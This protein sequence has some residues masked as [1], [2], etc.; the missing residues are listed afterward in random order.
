[1]SC[2]FGKQRN[3]ITFRFG[4]KTLHILPDVFFLPFPRPLSP[5]HAHEEKYGWLARLNPLSAANTYWHKQ[6]SVRSSAANTNRRSPQSARCI[7]SGPGSSGRSWKYLMTLAPWVTCLSTT[8]SRFN[9]IR[10]D[11]SKCGAMA[12]WLMKFHACANYTTREIT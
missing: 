11:R 3:K 7:S 6:L 9:D 10:G 5:A 1:M 8:V 12:A 4:T 2:D